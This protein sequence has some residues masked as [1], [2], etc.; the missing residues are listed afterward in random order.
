MNK[1]L[2]MKHGKHGSHKAYPGGKKPKYY[3]DD[4]SPKGGSS[5]PA[6]GPKRKTLVK[7][8]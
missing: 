4:T 3:L 8:K 1:E 7:L 6:G 5:N 2:P